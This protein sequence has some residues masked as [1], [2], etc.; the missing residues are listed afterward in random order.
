MSMNPE[1][2]VRKFW[3]RVVKTDT[4]WLWTGG[5][6]PEGYGRLIWHG[7]S[8][9]AHRVS[10]ELHF[11]PI[12]EG[13]VI[14]HVRAR[15]CRNTGC[16]NPEHLEAVTRGENTMRGS[17]PPALNALKTV[18]PRGHEYSLRDG[19]RVCRPCE[20]LKSLRYQA[21]QRAKQARHGAEKALG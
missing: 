20:S 11:G 16:V 5:T 8:A 12:P 14:D 1:T 9:M 3:E 6:N 4:C 19:K 10:Y 2:Y 7:V 13:L 21:R 18:C 17:C 15:G